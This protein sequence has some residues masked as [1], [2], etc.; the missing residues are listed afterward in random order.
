MTPKP[1]RM[2]R[3]VAD[4][5]ADVR[6]WRDAGLSVGLV[7]TMGALHD[8]HLSLVKA[9][10]ATCD[11]VVVSLFVNPTQFGPHEDFSAYPRDEE[12]DRSLVEGEG[13]HLLF[14][15][16]VEEM[17]GP[18]EVTQV[19]VPGLDAVLEGAHRPGHFT[20]VATVVAKLLNL[21][22]ADHA[23][24]G[25]K[26]YQQLQVITR[27]AA[28]LCMPTHIH[29]VATVRESDGLAMSSRNVYLTPN[30][31]AIAPVLYATLAQV[32]DDFRAGRDGGRLE[33]QA[34]ETLAQAGFRPVDYV[35]IVDAAT[36]EPLHRYDAS[37]PARVIAAARLGRT[38][39]IDNLSVDPV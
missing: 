26:D 4:L 39:L 37:R 17:Y 30:E 7:P 19:H 3:T 16:S 12:R 2:A 13:A 10:L 1:L 29:G 33:V 11:R 27:M 34:R 35:A 8:G 28:D 38:R 32:A 5:R 15:P 9:A 18:Q 20:G 36:L 22:Q 21:V 24:F 25:E 23:F 14:A 6:G 31:R